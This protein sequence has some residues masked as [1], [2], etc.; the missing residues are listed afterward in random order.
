MK[1]VTVPAGLTSSSTGLTMSPTVVCGAWGFPAEELSV[2]GGAAG[3]KVSI[4]SCRL[5][6]EEGMSVM[7]RGDR[8]AVPQSLLFACSTFRAELP[9]APGTELC[10]APPAGTVLGVLYPALGARGK[11]AEPCQASAPGDSIPP[12]ILLCAGVFRAIIERPLPVRGSGGSPELYDD[13]I[14]AVCTASSATRDA[15]PIPS[16]RPLPRLF[17]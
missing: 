12:P 17:E 14:A 11:S 1:P 13:D 16:A 8:S 7:S 3:V 10:E 2:D 4:N 5:L 15:R 6:H 9:P